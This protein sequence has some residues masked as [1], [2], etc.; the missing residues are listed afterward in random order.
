M[1]EIKECST[2]ELRERYD[3]KSSIFS[4]KDT[5]KDR[6]GEGYFHLKEERRDEM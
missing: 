3:K 6:R 2:K 1:D 4:T 5:L